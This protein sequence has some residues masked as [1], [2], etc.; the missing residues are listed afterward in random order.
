MKSFYDIFN[1]SNENILFYTNEEDVFF[2]VF[3]CSLRAFFDL[4]DELVPTSNVE[5]GGVSIGK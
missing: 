3:F 2:Y 4:C 5:N 1:E